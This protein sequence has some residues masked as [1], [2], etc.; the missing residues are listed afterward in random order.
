MH[1][2]PWWRNSSV[3]KNGTKLISTLGWY[4]QVY[5]TH[6][7]P[8]PGQLLALQTFKEPGRSA[9]C[10]PS[11]TPT[12][13]H[14]E[15]R[16]WRLVLPTKEKALVV[17]AQG[18][19]SHHPSS[20]GVQVW[21]RKPEQAT[22]LMPV[23]AAEWV[24]LPGP[25]ECFISITSGLQGLKPEL[26]CVSAAEDDCGSRASHGAWVC[27]YLDGKFQA[28]GQNLACLI[29]SKFQVTST[30]SSLSLYFLITL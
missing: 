3:E 6:V 26:P 16:T 28:D 7:F 19:Y 15:F 9:C 5:V 18:G 22:K 1:I 23:I 30:N 17:K 29:E 8:S 2:H 13:I 21:A 4:M 11:L 10:S 14:R 12:F 25:A 20:S 27:L 24:G